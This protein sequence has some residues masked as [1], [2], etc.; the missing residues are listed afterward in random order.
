MF[1]TCFRVTRRAI[2]RREIVAVPSPCHRRAPHHEPRHRRTVASRASPLQRRLLGRARAVSLRA[3]DRKAEPP[4][5]AVHNPVMGFRSD[6]ASEVRR[7]NHGELSN[8]RLSTKILGGLVAVAGVVIT[9][10]IV[11]HGLASGPPSSTTPLTI[12]ALALYTA[13]AVGVIV[14]ADIL[15]RVTVRTLRR[16]MGKTR[17]DAA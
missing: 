14:F 12:L 7:L 2:L 11:A 1:L 5:A 13:V 8:L 10:V 16:H 9:V 4:R 15:V 6:F 3:H 17:R